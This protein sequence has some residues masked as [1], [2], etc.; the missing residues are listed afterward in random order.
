MHGG[1]SRGNGFTLIEL[2]VVIAI[3]AILAAILFPVLTAAK[4]SA[5]KTKCSSNLRQMGTAVQLYLDNNNGKFPPDSHSDNIHLITKLQPYSNSQLLYR[6]PSDISKNFEKPLP[7]YRT[8][9]RSSYGSNFY[10]APLAPGEAA[11]GTHGFTDASAFGQPS[12]TIYI[13]EMKMNS[14]ADH[15]HPAYWTAGTREPDYDGMGMTIHGD[16]ANYLFLDGHVR[17]MKFEETWKRDGAI[18]F[19]DP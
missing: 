13:A 18:N 10:M 7:G 3:I 2:L 14:T 6:C 1:S 16:K 8:R 12:R 9:R 17:P 15:F 4:E 11:D 19:Y 5:K